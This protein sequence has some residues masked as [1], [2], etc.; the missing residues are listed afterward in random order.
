MLYADRTRAAVAE[1]AFLPEEW[2]TVGTLSDWELRL[3]PAQADA[4][5]HKLA[6]VIAEAEAVE[7]DEGAPFVVNLNAYPRP[8]QAWGEQEDA[9]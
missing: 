7:A 5:V 1:M 4:L 2:R 3:T 9:R 6:E 8:G